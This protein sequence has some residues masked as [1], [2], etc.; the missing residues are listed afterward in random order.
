MISSSKNKTDAQDLI[1]FFASDDAMKV[2][3][4]YGFYEVE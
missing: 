4:K 2:F 3:K 1:D